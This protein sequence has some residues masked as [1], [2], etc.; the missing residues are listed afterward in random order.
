MAK[1]RSM[2]MTGAGKRKGAASMARRR[3]QVT[4]RRETT[5]MGTWT[6]DVSKCRFCLCHV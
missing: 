5:P 2:A 3:P 6:H 4:T 1:R